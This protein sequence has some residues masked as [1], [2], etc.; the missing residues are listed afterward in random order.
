M[1]DLED[2]LPP[3]IGGTLPHDAYI[4]VLYSIAKSLKRIADT[5]EKSKNSS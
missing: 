2:V 1:R 3:L 4:K 5:L